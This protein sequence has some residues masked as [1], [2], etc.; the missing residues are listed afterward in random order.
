MKLLMSDIQNYGNPNHIEKY[1]KNLID[2][3]KF[4]NKN[5]YIYIFNSKCY[6]IIN[7]FKIGKQKI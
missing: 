5:S 7:N 3:V 6:A 2:I 1:I 4:K